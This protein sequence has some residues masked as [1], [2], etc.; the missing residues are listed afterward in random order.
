MVSLCQLT[1]GQGKI[2]YKEEQLILIMMRDRWYMQR[3]G[4]HVFGIPMTLL[5]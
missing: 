4:G 1:T 2:Y 5:R 3:T